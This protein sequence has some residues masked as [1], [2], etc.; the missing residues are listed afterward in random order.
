MLAHYTEVY[1]TS[2][3]FQPLPILALDGLT[4]RAHVFPRF[5]QSS[6]LA[7]ALLYSSHPYFAGSEVEAASFYAKSTQRTVDEV[8]AAGSVSLEVLQALC[9]L[10]LYQVKSM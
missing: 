1:K 6:I 10:S 3:Y 7:L 2:I 5:L 4:S 9:F 8:V